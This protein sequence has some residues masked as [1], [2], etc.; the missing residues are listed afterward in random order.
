MYNSH[1]STKLITIRFGSTCHVEQIL[2]IF[3]YILLKTL[4]MY[5]YLYYINH[6]A[7][8]VPKHSKQ[9]VAFN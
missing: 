3:I 5:I 1:G 8:T 9:K 7:Q 2:K 4:N 6:I